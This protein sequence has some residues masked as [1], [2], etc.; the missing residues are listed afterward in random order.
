MGIRPKSAHDY[1][2]IRYDLIQRYK[3]V[4]INAL[5]LGNDYVLNFNV[6]L[7]A[8]LGGLAYQADWL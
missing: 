8:N 6:V 3:E 2:N 1:N 5:T 7:P 4:S